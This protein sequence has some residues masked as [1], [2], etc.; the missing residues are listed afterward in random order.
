M[1]LL[2]FIFCHFVYLGS[3]ICQYWLIIG[4]QK[5]N[6]K[7]VVFHCFSHWTPKGLPR[8]SPTIFPKL[9]IFYMFLTARST[10]AVILGSLGRLDGNHMSKG[11]SGR[12]GLFR[13]PLSTDRPLFQ[14]YPPIRCRVAKDHT[15]RTLICRLWAG[16]EVHGSS[17]NLPKTPLRPTPFPSLWAGGIR[18]AI[19]LFNAILLL[20]RILP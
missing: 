19:Q 10:S 6:E 17:G 12:S 1:F 16:S 4:R 20:L 8:D 15:I 3:I 5:N 9:M 11:I 14:I 7:P 2:F 13:S 18:E